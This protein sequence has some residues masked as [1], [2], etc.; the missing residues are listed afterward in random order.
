MN[1]TGGRIR[2]AAAAGVV[3]IL[4]LLGNPSVRASDRSD[5]EALTEKARVTIQD[6]AASKDYASL[7]LALGHA[8][9]V[10]IFPNVLKAGFFL[11]G[12]VAAAC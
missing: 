3:A 1:I 9:A 6:F 7:K 11:G 5:A 2:V 8:K 4:A 12:P 10:L